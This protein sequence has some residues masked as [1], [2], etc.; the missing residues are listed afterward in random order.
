MK[1]LVIGGA[2]FIGSNLAHTLLSQGDSVIVL[3]N[4]SRLGS[5]K[6]LDWLRTLHPDLGGKMVNA[7]GGFNS[8]I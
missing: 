4:L 5:Q 1:H 2:G 6:N 8:L 7:V 3:D